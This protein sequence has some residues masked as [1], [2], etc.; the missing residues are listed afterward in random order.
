MKLHSVAS[1]RGGKRQTAWLL[2]WE[3]A[4]SLLAMLAGCTAPQEAAGAGASVDSGDVDES[5]SSKLQEIQTGSVIALLGER[6]Q[7][8][9]GA[10]LVDGSGPRLVAGSEDFHA[11]VDLEGE[12]GSPVAAL[13][14]GVV[15]R[16]NRASGTE[17]NHVYVLHSLSSPIRFHGEQV[18]SCWS[19]YS[20]AA[21][22]G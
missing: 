9:E 18:T 17:S 11:G 14:E 16:V 20:H 7:P 1:I 22:G 4:G 12:R 10:G 15:D 21:P 5:S 6:A 19:L 8:A 3:A 13:S 2:G